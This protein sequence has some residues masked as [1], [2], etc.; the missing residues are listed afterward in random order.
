[1]LQIGVKVPTIIIT[2]RI[3]VPT[4]KITTIV[5]NL[6]SKSFKET[7]ME[8]ALLWEAP[9]YLHNQTVSTG[10]YRGTWLEKNNLSILHNNNIRLQ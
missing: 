2:I 6:K 8:A 3:R 7:E 10:I 4:V 1:M 5:Q 9:V